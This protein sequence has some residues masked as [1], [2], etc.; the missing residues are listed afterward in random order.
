MG[1]SG[2]A[3]VTHMFVCD[4]ES[5]RDRRPPQTAAGTARGDCTCTHARARGRPQGPGYTHT[6]CGTPGL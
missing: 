4:H 1:S 6:L 5:Q 3:G 2:L